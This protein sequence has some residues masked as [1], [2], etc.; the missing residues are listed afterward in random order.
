MKTKGS[1]RHIYVYLA[2]D[3]IHSYSKFFTFVRDPWI[4]LWCR[5]FMSCSFF[6]CWWFGVGEKLRNF[7]SDCASSPL[8][9]Y[10][11]GSGVDI[12]VYIVWFHSFEKKT[13]TYKT[14]R[15]QR[16]IA[17]LGERGHKLRICPRPKTQLQAAHWKDLH[18]GNEN[19]EEQFS[20]RSE[21]G[22]SNWSIKIL[23][24][25]KK[26]CGSA[27][28]LKSYNTSKCWDKIPYASILSNNFFERHDTQ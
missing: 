25:V 2:I 8:V 9:S 3:R 5:W 20:Q 14:T 10:S 7:I 4:L 27:I 17:K 21:V 1:V 11:E 18:K 24:I 22:T 12:S 15:L 16:T 19:E 28:C 6:F 26:L 13:P 23:N